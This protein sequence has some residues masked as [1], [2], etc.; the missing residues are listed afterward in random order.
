MIYYV[1]HT[2]IDKAR[3]IMHDLQ[4]TDLDNCYI[5]PLLAF[6]AVEDGEIC[7]N[8]LEQLRL[9][10]LS[11]S[12]VLIIPQDVDPETL[13][14]YKFACEVGMEVMCLGKD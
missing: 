8:A 9:D 3:S 10:M 11:V 1:A 4:I 14:E 13:G 12:D 2:D 5:S 6:S 7:E